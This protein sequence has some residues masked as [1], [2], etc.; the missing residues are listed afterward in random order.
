MSYVVLSYGSLNVLR[1]CGLKNRFYQSVFDYYCKHGH[2]TPKQ[3]TCLR[4]GLNVVRVEDAVPA[5]NLSVAHPEVLKALCEGGAALPNDMLA[6]GYSSQSVSSSVS[7]QSSKFGKSGYRRVY[8]WEPAYDI[9]V[10]DADTIGSSSSPSMRVSSNK[11]A[12]SYNFM[13]GR[14]ST[15]VNLVEVV[16][17]SLKDGGKSSGVCSG[18][19]KF[20]SGYELSGNTY[21]PSVKSLNKRGGVEDRSDDSADISKDTTVCC[22][23][24]VST[25]INVSKP[26]ASDGVSIVSSSAYFG[27]LGVSACSKLA[28]MYKDEATKLGFN[29]YY[30]GASKFYEWQIGKLPVFDLPAEVEVK[31]KSFQVSLVKE[32]VG[33]LLSNSLSVK[34]Q[35][36]AWDM[37]AGKTYGA[38]GVIRSL[39]DYRLASGLSTE[40]VGVF[41]ICPKSVI[42]KWRSVL[43]Y[44]GVHLLGISNYEA[45]VRGKEVR[46]DGKLVDCEY[47]NCVFD[48]TKAIPRVLSY[49]FNFPNGSC[50][51]FDEL[52]RCKNQGTMNSK[53]AVAGRHYLNSCR[54]SFGLGL[55]GTLAESPLKT[56]ASGYFLGLYDSKSDFYSRVI[57]FG[58]SRTGYNDSWEFKYPS[59]FKNINLA[60]FPRIGSRVK[61]SD[62]PDAPNQSVSVEFISVSSGR[63]SKLVSVSTS[64]SISLFSGATASV[65]GRYS[66]A[67]LSAKAKLKDAVGMVKFRKLS[68][69]DGASYDLLCLLRER[70]LRELE[71][72]PY[73]YDRVLSCV[74]SGERCVVFLNF[75]E[76]VEILYDAFRSSQFSA[77][78]Y[79]GVDRGKTGNGLSLRDYHLNM[80]QLNVLPVLVCNIEAAKEGIDMHDTSFGHRFPRVAF[81]SPCYNGQTV[82][83]ALGRVHRVGGGFCRQVFV[84]SEGTVEE[85]VWVSIADKL[86]SLDD[87]NDGE[88]VLCDSIKVIERDCVGLYEYL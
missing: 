60:L 44:F 11:P 12:K 61:F 48:E 7:N 39:S 65:L 51:L 8:D 82:S 27:S 58:A 73:L 62:I 64:E 22:D 3:F 9:E 49:K 37:G 13:G 52:H 17:K 29:S 77:G 15:S 50:I 1:K 5:D 84:V 78:I 19:S 88:S 54:D 33:K 47:I 71:K 14:S 38:A 66:E 41:V 31:L 2:I 20:A 18:E 6:A 10:A 46:S 28:G 72:L 56:W 45:A 26:T 25:T 24:A 74:G 75:T 40:P 80:F 81:F 69:R 53:L 87:L 4:R 30:Y 83:Q 34:S 59:M 76:S 55:S 16:H 21:L 68:G 85:K 79:D 36:L 43:S 42:G 70:Q 57:D 23:S 86:D 63:E 35:L 32:V 67:V